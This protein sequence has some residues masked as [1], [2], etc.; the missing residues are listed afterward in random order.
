MNQNSK[1]KRL[2]QHTRRRTATEAS[3]S[4]S[5]FSCLIYLVFVAEEGIVRTHSSGYFIRSRVKQLILSIVTR[6]E[7]NNDRGILSHISR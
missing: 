1:E 3:K 4:T 2:A 6:I 7:S 5:L